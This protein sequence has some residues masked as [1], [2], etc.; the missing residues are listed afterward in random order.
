MSDKRQI[1][2]HIYWSP[3][4]HETAYSKFTK[5]NK[6]S[7]NFSLKR[8]IDG[9]KSCLICHLALIKAALVNLFFKAVSKGDL[10]IRIKEQ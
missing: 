8:R 2:S 5:K 6:K 3:P 7:K 4:P 1:S 10:L 9:C